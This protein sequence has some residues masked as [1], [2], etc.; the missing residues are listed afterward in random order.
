MKGGAAKDLKGARPVQVL[1]LLALLSLLRTLVCFTG[2]NVQILTLPMQRGKSIDK[3]DDA[4]TEA[5][6]ALL[7]IAGALFACFTSSLLALLVVFRTT[8]RRRQRRRC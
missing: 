4:E 7:E 6:A 5:A 3:E 8:T 1:S 2:T